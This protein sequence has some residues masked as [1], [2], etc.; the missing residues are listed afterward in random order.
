MKK[1]LSVLLISALILALAACG[2]RSEGAEPPKSGEQPAEEPAGQ[3]Q[4]TDDPASAEEKEPEEETP[5]EDDRPVISFE[6]FD[7]DG[8]SVS[9]A[10]IFAENE[11]TIIN[12]WGTYCGPCIREMPDLAKLSERLKDKNCEIV[13]IVCDVAGPSDTAMIETAKKILEETGVSYLN[14]LPWANTF[15]DFPAQF[16]PTT[17]FVD[18]K[19]HIVGEALIGA[20]SADDYEELIDAALESLE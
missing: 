14:L 4:E 16:I 13:G 5:A 9:S 10:D 20:R 3:E 8:N 11:L 7:I 18:S 17:Y 12:I 19:G 15:G 6:T 2:S 1:L